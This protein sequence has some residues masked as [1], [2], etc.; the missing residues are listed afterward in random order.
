[1]AGPASLPAALGLPPWASNQ[2]RPS[3][4]KRRWQLL[5]WSIVVLKVRGGAK[6]GLR[7]RP[8]RHIPDKKGRERPFSNGVADID[9]IVAGAAARSTATATLAALANDQ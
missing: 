2:R 1:M 5:F 6:R 9:R 8:N 4:L 7:V 3:G